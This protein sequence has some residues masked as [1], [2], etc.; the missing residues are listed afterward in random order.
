MRIAPPC[1]LALLALGCGDLQPPQC[2]E[3]EDR[4]CFRGVF[5]TLLGGPIENMKVCAPEL[6]ELGCARTDEGGGWKLPGLPRDTNVVLTAAHPDY[7]PT[8]F[9]QNT[10]MSWYAW[11]KV[12]VPEGIAESN[13]KRLDLEADPDKGSVLFLTW[14]GLN[15]DGEDTPKVSDVTVETR[16]RDGAVFYANGL[17]VADPDAEATTGSG[18][19]GALNVPVGA[20]ELRLKAPGGRCGG[21]PMFHYPADADGWISVPVLAGWNSA[22]DVQ[23]PTDR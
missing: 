1:A 14:E 10:A 6:P 22:I 15:I 9:P 19:G 7:V 12:G 3:G 16:G 18:M 11:Y 13:A 21:E 20:L 4:A 2:K 17:G 5:K 23:C 8:A